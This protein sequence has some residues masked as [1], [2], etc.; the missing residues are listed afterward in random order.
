VEPL[1]A[2]FSRNKYDIP[3]LDHQLRTSLLMIMLLITPVCTVLAFYSDAIVFVLLGETWK[4]QG[5]LLANL[6]I[7]LMSFSLGSILG[8]FYIAM[9]KVKL[10]FFYNL[11]SLAFIFSFLLILAGDNLAEFALLRGVLGLI[12][13]SLW[14]LLALYFTSS[15]FPSFFLLLST[16]VL[17]SY[18][19]LFLTES[20]SLQTDSIY[21]SLAW[22]VASFGVFYLLLTAFFYA[23][24]FNR[25]KEWH[26]LK[27]L[28]INPVLMRISK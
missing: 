11:L 17:L 7:L 9:G 8:N 26:H 1:L 2:S 21:L 24:L 14:L 19:A 10:L 25:I 23:A 27:T 6:T 15:R 12:S 16:P 3:A 13:T 20:F 22:D 4:G 28:L 5:P 18:L